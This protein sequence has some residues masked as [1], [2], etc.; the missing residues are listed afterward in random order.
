MLAA[1]EPHAPVACVRNVQKVSCWVMSD[2]S[3]VAVED[4]LKGRVDTGRAGKLRASQSAENEV[5]HGQSESK[6][7]MG[8][9]KSVLLLST[10][11]VL[12]VRTVLFMY[13][14]R[15]W[16]FDVSA[17]TRPP[18]WGTNTMP[19][20]PLKRALEPIASKAPKLSEP[21]TVMRLSAAS[22]Q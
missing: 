8:P 7:T 4:C 17:M 5:K 19:E 22:T 10:D 14:T 3:R 2:R 18:S 16:L 9:C 15:S 13:S 6:R 21:A 12:T 11:T 1:S 20:G